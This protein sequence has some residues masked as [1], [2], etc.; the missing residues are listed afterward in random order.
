MRNIIIL[1]L[2]S[3]VTAFSQVKTVKLDA[4]TSLLNNDADSVY[5]INFWATWCKPC[6]E[7]LP[8]FEEATSAFSQKNV[9][10]ILVSLDSPLELDRVLLPFVKKKDLKSEI[11]LLDEQNPNEWI[12]K[13]ETEWTGSLPATIILR[14]RIKKR[15]FLEKQLEKEELFTTIQSMME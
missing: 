10:V 8:Y 13:I 1:L 6:I 15:V 14:N 11:L 12:D 2:F 4:L 5:V 7:E 9:R 3:T